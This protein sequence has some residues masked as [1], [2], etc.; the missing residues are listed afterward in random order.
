MGKK[1]RREGLNDFL[2]EVYLENSEL[3][4]KIQWS[5]TESDLSQYGPELQHGQQKAES[6]CS[7]PTDIKGFRPCLRF[8][9]TVELEGLRSFSVL[10]ALGTAWESDAQQ[11]P[12]LFIVMQQL[13]TKLT[14]SH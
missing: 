1:R 11:G 4:Y 9:P 7:M 14:P 13:R 8:M 3:G 2:K 12:I 6:E 10:P 5:N